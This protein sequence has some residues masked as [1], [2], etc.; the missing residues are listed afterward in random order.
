MRAHTKHTHACTLHTQYI[1]GFHHPNNHASH[2]TANW[3]KSKHHYITGNVGRQHKHWNRV[4]YAPIW[5]EW[6]NKQL[7]HTNRMP[8]ASHDRSMGCLRSPQ[9]MG[10]TQS[11]TSGRATLTKCPQRLTT[12]PW[13]A[14]EVHSYRVGPWAVQVVYYTNKMPTGSP[15]RSI[16]LRGPYVRGGTLSRAMPPPP[17]STCPPHPKARC[18][19]QELR[20]R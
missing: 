17:T 11:S 10:G 13:V 4:C 2:I 15:D 18:M 3:H 5:M 12:G 16:F 14:L 6:D 1:I 20:V 7:Y 9:L 8:P 19:G